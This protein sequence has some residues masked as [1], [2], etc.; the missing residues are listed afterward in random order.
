MTW[1][2]GH[3]RFLAHHPLPRL[4]FVSLGSDICLQLPSDPPSRWAPLLFGEEFLSSRPPRDLHPL[5]TSRLA[6]A[7][8]LPAPSWRCAPCLAHVGEPG[9][10]AATPPPQNG[11][12]EFPHKPLKPFQ[13][14]GEDATGRLF[15]LGCGLAYGSWGEE[16]RGFPPHRCHREIATRYDGCAIPLAR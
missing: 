9:S 10:I 14:P 16:G 2:F 11:S 8:R 12:D 5:V 3:R 6:F 13:R 1:G 15:T 7:F 4:R